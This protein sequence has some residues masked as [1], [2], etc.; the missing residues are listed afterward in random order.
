MHKTILLLNKHIALARKKNFIYEQIDIRLK[1]WTHDFPATQTLGLIPIVAY[2]S[3]VMPYLFSIQIDFNTSINWKQ[4]KIR[5]QFLYFYQFIFCI[6]HG[7]SRVSGCN[8]FF[9]IRTLGNLLEYI[10]C[11]F[12]WQKIE[13]FVWTFL[14]H[15]HKTNTIL[16]YF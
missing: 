1:I 16:F 13:F 8:V 14:P 11:S 7:K 2:N 6:W 5:L 15:E 3:A 12:H 10:N 4:T 9:V